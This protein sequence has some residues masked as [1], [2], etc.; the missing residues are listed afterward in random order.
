MQPPE[1]EG[2]AAEALHLSLSEFKHPARLHRFR[3]SGIGQVS[4]SIHRSWP[5]ATIAAAVRNRFAV[6]ILDL[7]SAPPIHLTPFKALKS[8]Q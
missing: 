2:D 7:T 4:I 8:L 1:E 5:H 3:P 6:A